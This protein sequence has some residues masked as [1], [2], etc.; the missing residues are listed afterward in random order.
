MAQSI[1]EHDA[2]VAKSAAMIIGRLYENQAQIARFLHEMLAREVPEAAADGELLALLYDSTQGNI[3]AFFP[4][5]RHDIAIERIEPPTAALEHARR[6]AQRGITADALV[7]AYRLGHQAVINLVLDEIRAADFD[8]Q[9][10]LD[11]FQQIAS[12]S[13][14]YIDRITQLALAAYQVERDR[15]LANQ[16]RVRALRVRE[17]IDA[18]EIDIDETSNVI[19]YPLRC[20]H[21]SAVVWCGESESGN[22]L[23][24][25]ERFINELG[26]SLGAQQRPLFVAADR[27]T[28]WAW[29][30]LPADGATNLVARARTFAAGRAD[31]P[32]IAIGS[33]LP[34]I[35]GFRRSHQQAQAARA[36]VMAGRLREPRV[37]AASDPG[38]AVAAQFSS[39][40][41]A[42]RAWVGEVLGP[43]A[44]ATDVD[45]RLRETLRVF[46]HTGSSFKAAA[47]E[48]H[49]HSNSVKYRVQRAVERRSKP[50]TDDRLDVE[51]ALLLCHWFDTAVLS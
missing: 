48:L 49:L 8:T 22:E 51:V 9:L 26:K 24:V 14:L 28:G 32:W 36:V 11:V 13:F 23:V 27:V 29:I 31:A 43:L 15:W 5:V 20:L 42:A 2:L 21:L 30:P 19:G 44:S 3:D 33:S 1:G 38:L 41:G 6:L 25:M 50:I 45:E 7:R 37:T 39:D 16:N 17:I 10:T 35:E 18:G 4:A 34:G 12:T 47:D 46:L 40:L